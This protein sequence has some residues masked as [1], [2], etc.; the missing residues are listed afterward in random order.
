[1]ECRRTMRA[2]TARRD[3]RR[4]HRRPQTI[5]ETSLI[6][7]ERRTRGSSPFFI[8]SALIN[9]ASGQVSDQIRLQGSQTRGGAGM[10]HRRHATGTTR[11]L[12]QGE[13]ADVMRRRRARA[14]IGRIGIAASSLQG[15]VDRTQRHADQASAPVGTKGATARDGRGAGASVEALRARQEA[16]AKIYGEILGYGLSANATKSRRRRRKATA[17]CAACRAALKRAKLNVDQIDTGSTR[18]LDDGPTG[19][20]SEPSSGPSARP[21]QALDVVHQVGARPWLG[22][23]ARRGD[24]S[25]KSSST[26]RCRRT[27]NSTSRT[28]G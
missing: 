17:R 18:H 7:K 2:A 23:A 25:L 14:A 24:Y 13:D 22:A 3:D 11:A 26:R 8:P 6:L 20:T 12:I 27:L 15:P 1:M 19:S 28:E 16:R 9:L 4:R 5:Y 21:L 10:R